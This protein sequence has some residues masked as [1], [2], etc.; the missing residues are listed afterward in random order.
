MVK[1]YSQMYW[2]AFI[3]YFTN[4]INILYYDFYWNLYG[5]Y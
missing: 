3:A 5:K 2:Q 1:V 4:S